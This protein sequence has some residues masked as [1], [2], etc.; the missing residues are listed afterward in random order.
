MTF[1]LYYMFVLFYVDDIV[2]TSNNVNA[3]T[4]L[5]HELGKELEVI[6]LGYL[7]VMQ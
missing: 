7:G 6:L 4:G 5:I 1:Y 2:V 3:I